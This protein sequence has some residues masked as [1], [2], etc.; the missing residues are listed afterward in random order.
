MIYEIET[1]A[2]F[3]ECLLLIKDSCIVSTYPYDYPMR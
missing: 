1:L 3:I 2:K